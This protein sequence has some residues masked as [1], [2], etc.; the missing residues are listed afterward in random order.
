MFITIC[1]IHIKS[2]KYTKSK[3]FTYLG[4]LGL[5]CSMWDLVPWPGIEPR[6]LR[7]EQGVLA[8]G[9]RGKSPKFLIFKLRWNPR[10]MKS[11]I[12]RVQACGMEYTRNGV[13]PLPLPR[14]KPG[15]AVSTPR[16][17]LGPLSSH[18][19]FLPVP[20]QLPR[21]F[22]CLGTHL[23]WTLHVNGSRQCVTYCAWPLPLSVM[24]SCFIHTGAY[25]STSF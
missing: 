21:C 10:G 16:G 22:L 2:C 15:R 19:L 7:W 25:A 18:S 23:L 20:F 5:S 3:I 9:P 24:L 12:L 17:D 11:A 8:T 13:Q 4:I 6:P 14:P 1:H